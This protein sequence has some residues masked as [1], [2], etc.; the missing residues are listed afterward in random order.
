MTEMDFDDIYENRYSALLDTG[1]IGGMM[2]MA[3]K[4][5]EKGFYKH[6][7]VVLEIGAGKGQ[8]LEFVKHT[9]D[10]YLESDIRF[11]LLRGATTK[12]VPAPGVKQ[13]GLDAQDLRDIQTG[14]VN[15]V[16]ATCLIAHLGDP[17]AA[18]KEI[19]R[20]LVVGGEVALYIPSEPGLMLRLAR[21][22][23]TV[24]KAKRMGYQ[25][26]PFHYQE[27]RN[28][29]LFLKYILKEVFGDDKTSF[30]SFPIPGLSWNFSLW[31]VFT[32]TKL[33]D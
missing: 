32:A 8:H 27:H 21:Y 14:S 17:K 1:L 12:R 22:L 26:L 16:I 25:H 29:Y 3:H 31:K 24:Q 9:F 11:D 23:T 15:R 20:V 33:K 28:H 10:E 4:S 19:R 5:L 13:I 6:Y 30:R 18:L 7:P 2:G